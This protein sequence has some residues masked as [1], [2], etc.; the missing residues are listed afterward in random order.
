MLTL[1]FASGQVCVTHELVWCFRHMI[2]EKTVW[3]ALNQRKMKWGGGGGKKG[4]G[5]DVIIKVGFQLWS[6]CFRVSRVLLLMKLVTLSPYIFSSIPSPSPLFTA[7]LFSQV[8]QGGGKDVHIGMERWRHG[9]PLVEE[10][11]ACSM[12]CGHVLWHIANF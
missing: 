4:Q 12:R 1:K 3:K 11:E 6:S 8:I 7:R 10:E 9:E 2:Q 5:W